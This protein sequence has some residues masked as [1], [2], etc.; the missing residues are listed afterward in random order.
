MFKE[1]GHPL[2]VWP[3]KATNQNAP[4]QT[5]LIIMWLAMC[6]DK[7]LVVEKCLLNGNGSRIFVPAGF[8]D[9]RS[10][11]A[12]LEGRRVECRGV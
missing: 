4:L 1:H 3:N 8:S 7:R 10:I 5:C 11:N 6:V 2:N 9:G 12:E